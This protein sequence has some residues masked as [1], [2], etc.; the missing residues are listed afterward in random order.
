MIRE[1]QT[2]NRTPALTS[3]L[4]H[5]VHAR[6]DGVARKKPLFVREIVSEH[7]ARETAVDAARALR[8][9]VAP[10]MAERE[11]HLRDQ[12]FVRQPAYQSLIT[13]ERLK[14]RLR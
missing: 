9:T 14:R 7:D 12:I 10:T 13:A 3:D 4:W 1:T 8:G 6:W 11:E 2:A 5:V